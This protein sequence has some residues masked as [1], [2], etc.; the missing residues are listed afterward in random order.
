LAV[1]RCPQIWRKTVVRISLP[2]VE[3]EFGKAER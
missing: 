1:L 3:L 2:I